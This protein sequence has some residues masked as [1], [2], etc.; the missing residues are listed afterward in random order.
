MIYIYSFVKQCKFY[1]LCLE[2]IFN[3]V[4]IQV[5][6]KHFY[7][8]KYNLRHLIEKTIF[9]NSRYDHFVLICTEDEYKK[10]KYVWKLSF[11]CTQMAKN[12]F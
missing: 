6:K 2:C 8:N 7:L 11:Q 3:V 4:L 1:L 5:K 12:D 10:E 9:R